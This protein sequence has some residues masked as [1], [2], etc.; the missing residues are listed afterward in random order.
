VSSDNR[1]QGSPAEM[2]ALLRANLSEVRD[3]LQRVVNAGEAWISS[4]DDEGRRRLPSFSLTKARVVLAECDGWL[5]LIDG[6]SGDPTNENV[7]ALIIAAGQRGDAQ[8]AEPV[9][10]EESSS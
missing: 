5:T 4:H 1:S 9:A 6:L 10:A 7:T 8:P 3:G 2:L